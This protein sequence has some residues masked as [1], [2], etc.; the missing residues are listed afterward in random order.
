[1]TLADFVV[2][3][4]ITTNLRATTKEG[5]FREIVRNL[6]D[7]GQL[8][9][10]DSEELIRALLEREERGPQSIGRGVAFPEG[11]HMA[12]DRLIGTIALSRR[13]L[14]FGAFDGKPVDIFVILLKPLKLDGPVRAIDLLEATMAVARHF[15]KDDFLARLRQCRTGD[16]VFELIVT[17]EEEASNAAVDCH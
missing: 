9:A 13:G 4:A 7:A 14:D 3:N 17:V 10:A 11:R 16:D 15:T 8:A 12:V 2:R 5:V 1:M 6:Q